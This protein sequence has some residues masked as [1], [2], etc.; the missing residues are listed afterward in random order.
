MNYV[1]VEE[2]IG[3]PGLRLVLSAGVPGPWGESAKYILHAKRIPYTAVRQLAGTES[4]ALRR[5]TGQSNAP[6]AVY[7]SESPRSGW[8]EILALAERLAPEPS[9]VPE[10]PAQ[11]VRMFG[12]SHEICAEGGF[13][14]Q[15]RLMLIAA[16][17]TGNDVTRTLAR[18]YGYND[19]ATAAAPGRT[20]EI[21]LLLSKQ[22]RAQRALGSPYF[23]GERLSA[24]DLYWAAFALMLEPLGDDHCK[25]HPRL[26]ESYAL[27]DA[28]VRAAADEILL[29]HRDFIYRTHLAL[30]LDF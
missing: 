10:D 12:L 17:G 22:L 26:R 13:G 4:E 2:A 27:R 8:A 5:W 29:E 15:R 16:L 3:L 21:L 25:L 11:R 24:L 9:L 19:A 18:R 28:A 14:W 1:E 30:P 20:A 7:G 6:I 23:V